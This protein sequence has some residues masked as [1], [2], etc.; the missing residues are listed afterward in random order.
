MTHMKALKCVL[1]I[2]IVCGGSVTASGVRAERAGLQSTVD[3]AFDSGAPYYLP[4]RVVVGAQTAIRWWN[5]TASPHSIRHDGC[6]TDGPCAFH[7]LAV[8]PDES[9]V[10]APLPPGRYPYHC[11]LHPIMRGLLLVVEGNGDADL[12]P[13]LVGAHAER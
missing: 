5:P 11:E 6:A 8:L 13:P 12:V 10:I 4:N 1:A 7:S 3:I 2:A 9:F